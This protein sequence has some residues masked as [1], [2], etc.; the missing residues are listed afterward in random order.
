MA[1]P[2][3]SWGG[4]PSAQSCAPGPVVAETTFVRTECGGGVGA[5]GPGVG[6]SPGP[7]PAE[8]AFPGRN[9]AGALPKPAPN[10]GGMP[11]AHVGSGAGRGRRGVHRWGFRP[12]RLGLMHRGSEQKELHRRGRCSSRQSGRRAEDHRQGPRCTDESWQVGTRRDRSDSRAAR[13][14]SGRCATGCL[15]CASTTSLD[16]LL[17][18]HLRT[19]KGSRS[20]APIT[21]TRSVPEP[22]ST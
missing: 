2:A 19:H 1:Q 12:P 18:S 22:S 5:S 20:E 8:A 14:R 6:G 7:F 21:T 15:S 10:R 4:M 17:T 9:A 3:P 16:A 11:S 13:Y